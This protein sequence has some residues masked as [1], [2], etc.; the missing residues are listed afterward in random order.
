VSSKRAK[1]ILQRGR[2]RSTGPLDKYFGD[3]MRARRM[4]IKMSQETLGEKLGV[5]FQQIQKYE[6]GINRLSA[7]TMVGFA[8]ALDIDVGYFYDEMP[9]TKRSGEIE[10]PALTELA[11]KLHG[12]RMID[13]FLK[14]KNDKMRGAVA[15]LV[16]S[17]AR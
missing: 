3:R 7:A 9:K 5:T 6:K 12:R 1:P 15:D 4:M 2:S 16:Q 11:L 14:L 17:L 13:G 10:T 8:E